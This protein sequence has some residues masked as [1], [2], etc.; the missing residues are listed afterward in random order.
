M[1]HGSLETKL[2]LVDRMEQ[3]GQG[4]VLGKSNRE[5]AEELGLKER[6]LKVWCRKVYAH[7]GIQENNGWAARLRLA[8]L[9]RGKLAD[10]PKEKAS[11]HFSPAEQ[12][13]IQLL[14]EE[15][16]LAAMARR[17]GW[18]YVATRNRMRKIYDKT[19]M[20]NRM[21]LLQWVLSHEF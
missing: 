8:Q 20:S 19:G 14:S 13:Q 17:M 10:G 6:T 3:V 5:M 18:T 21:E 12:Q 9:H 15:P 4:I 11:V 16:S 2:R 7:H 1:C